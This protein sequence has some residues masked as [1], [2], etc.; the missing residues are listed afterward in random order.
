MGMGVGQE[1]VGDG[2]G[3]NRDYAPTVMSVSY[4]RRC[5]KGYSLWLTYL[6]FLEKLSI[7]R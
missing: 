2:R 3:V 5:D 7:G 6:S 4:D 1:M